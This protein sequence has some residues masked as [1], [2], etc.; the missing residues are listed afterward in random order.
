MQVLQ[1]TQF[2]NVFILETDLI[3][4]M[5]CWH[6]IFKLPNSFLKGCRKRIACRIY[7]DLFSL[8]VPHIW[9]PKKKEGRQADSF[10]LME[11]IAYELI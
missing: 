5:D 9:E 10:I 2:K 11:T 3:L 8:T 7:N 6:L 1:T 4:V